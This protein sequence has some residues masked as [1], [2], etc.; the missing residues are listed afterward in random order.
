MMKMKKILKYAACISGVLLLASCA[1]EV[2]IPDGGEREDCLTFQCM[3]PFTKAGISGTASDDPTWNEDLIK[4]LD[5]YFY[6]A[7]DTTS[8]AVFHKQFTPNANKEYSTSINFTQGEINQIF[9]T[10]TYCTVYA[11]ANIDRSL[12]PSALT[13]TSMTAL[14]QILLPENKFGS[15]AGT[16][17]IMERFVMD[18]QNRVNLLSKTRTTVAVGTVP[19]YRVA[20]KIS[21]LI[22]VPDQ[23]D[24]P[25]TYKEDEE[26]I[27]EA[28]EVWE[29]MSGLNTLGT[30]QIEAYLENVNAVCRLGVRSYPDN[31]LVNNQTAA[32]GEY[33]SFSY[34]KNSSKY[35]NTDYITLEEETR[36][37]W[38]DHIAYPDSVTLDK[39]GTLT[40]N[41]AEVKYLIADHEYTYPMTW[42]TGS[43][44]E[45]YLKLVLPWKCSG[46]LKIYKNGR[47]HDPEIST[48]KTAQKQ[49]YY[50]IVFPNDEI[51]SNNW[52][53]YKIHIGILG[54]ESDDAKVTLTPTY[55]V[56]G[57]Q[58]KSEVLEEAEVGNARYL[59]V[60]Q[61]AYTLYN[62]VDLQIPYVTSDECEIVDAYYRQSYYGPSTGGMTQI[63][64]TW[65]TTGTAASA[66]ATIT[67]ENG[68][69][70]FQHTINNTMG[71]GMD[72]TPYTFTFRV[73]HKDDHSYFRD[74]TIYQYPA[75]Y[76]SMIPGGNVFIDGYFARVYNA[77][78]P[79]AI[80]T[81]EYKSSVNSTVNNAG[82]HTGPGTS[83]SIMTPYGTNYSS[84]SDLNMGN[85][86]RVNVSAFNESSKSCS[87]HGAT[88]GTKITVDYIIGDPRENAGWNNSSLEEYLSSQTLYN[89]NQYTITTTPWSDSAEKIMIGGSVPN[90]IAPSFFLSSS[91]S[92]KPTTETYTFERAQRRC[93]TY[94]EAGYPAGRW[95]LP[96]EA[97]VCF[98][99]ELQSNG[100][101]GTLF[102][103]TSYYWTSSGYR[104]QGGNY[105]SS[106]GSVAGGIR[107]VYDVWYWGENPQSVSTYHP[108]P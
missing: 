43:D 50:K 24:V 10:A 31:Y 71:T 27:Y 41:T 20:A 92:A 69:I 17:H 82:Y 64:G 108:E 61:E 14:K 90:I 13:G 30:R 19:L 96:T 65:Y 28:D 5:V 9:P 53:Q 83:T 33:V 76:I 23:I 11:I 37:T 60:A 12:L 100:F 15:V 22:H 54:S 70:D 62:E 34:K 2:T 103:S 42:V 68:Y 102:N 89:N 91:W 101:I 51:L 58:N 29:P 66:G 63:D 7:A 32:S 78:L 3:D 86:T 8:D 93:A 57:W 104:Y 1:K 55:M 56:A 97:E 80:G 77:T 59:S 46:T 73:Q 98:V 18:G 84:V 47:D 6:P 105:Y 44:I 75:I 35:V 4:T 88:N 39:V 26:H 36:Y 40:G 52:Y 49:F 38:S 99:R 95:R 107:C 106:S 79:G 48:C 67:C 16:S 45:P 25:T 85:L 81:G 72:V 94:Q 74:V 87:V 21:L